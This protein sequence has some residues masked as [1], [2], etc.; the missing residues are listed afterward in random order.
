ML[1]F[2]K[3]ELYNHSEIILHIE[4][5]TMQSGE[6]YYICGK[7]RSGKSLLLSAIAGEYHNF[8]GKLQFKG[9]SVTD[10]SFHDKIRYIKNEAA[11]FPGD[12]SEHNILISSKDKVLSKNLADLIPSVFKF[13]LNLEKNIPCAQLS[14]SELKLIEII[15]AYLQKPYVLLID[16]LDNYFDSEYFESVYSLISG[17]KQNGTLIIATGKSLIQNE[18]Q[19]L[20]SE[21]TLELK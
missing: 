16:D 17:L 15:R 12:N 5:L 20:I 1:T 7:N 10:K 19:Y 2:E 9:K 11:I 18:K 6:F 21:N 13:K 14:N 8:K 4:E 3:F